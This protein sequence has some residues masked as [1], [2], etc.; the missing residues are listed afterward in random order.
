MTREEARQMAVEYD[1]TVQ[2]LHFAMQSFKPIQ[3]EIDALHARACRLYSDLMTTGWSIP[4][5]LKEKE[6]E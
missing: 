6:E 1:E 4:E 3:R 5:L 2:D